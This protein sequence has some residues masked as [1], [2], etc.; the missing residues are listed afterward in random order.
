MNALGRWVRVLAPFGRLRLM[1]PIPAGKP[2]FRDRSLRFKKKRL[3]GTTRSVRAMGSELMGLRESTSAFAVHPPS[4]W[5]KPLVVLTEGSR[6]AKFWHQ[7]QEKL[8]NL[9]VAIEWQVADNAGH[10]I[11]QDRPGLIIDA[12][13]RTAESARSQTPERVRQF[14][15]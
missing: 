10:V 2:E 3:Q 5:D 12:I 9:S 8:T 6:R 14:G 15:R 1:M 7:L 4:L 13:G 11:H